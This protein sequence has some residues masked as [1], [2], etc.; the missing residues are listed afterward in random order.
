MFWKNNTLCITI[1]LFILTAPVI[2]D[3]TAIPTCTRGEIWT[4]GVSNYELTYQGQATQLGWTLEN[5]YNCSRD[6]CI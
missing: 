3:I 6:C 1:Y 4:S 5:I 2:C